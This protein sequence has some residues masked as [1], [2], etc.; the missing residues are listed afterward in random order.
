ML[1]V[2]PPAVL[3]HYLHEAALRAGNLDKASGA[4]YNLPLPK[5]KGWLKISQGFYP[6]CLTPIQF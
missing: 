1:S 2:L 3:I 4:K 5:N 6:T